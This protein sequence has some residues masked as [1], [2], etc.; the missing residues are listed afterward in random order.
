M[1][2]FNKTQSSHYE[3]EMNIGKVIIV[4]KGLKCRMDMDHGVSIQDDKFGWA[5]VNEVLRNL[6]LAEIVG[7]SQE[8]KVLLT[9]KKKDPISLFINK[10]YMEDCQI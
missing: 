1:N 8:S 9:G 10:Q 5:T 2:Q 7:F 4:I 6:K 3:V